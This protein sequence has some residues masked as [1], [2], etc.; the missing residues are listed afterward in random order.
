MTEERSEMRRL[1]SVG[2]ARLRA[3]DRDTVDGLFGEWRK[4]LA[5]SVV[6]DNDVFAAILNVMVAFAAAEMG[7]I[8]RPTAE[9]IESIAILAIRASKGLEA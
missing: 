5:A 2:L 6:S 9:T 3:S 8:G 7:R 1:L 4:I